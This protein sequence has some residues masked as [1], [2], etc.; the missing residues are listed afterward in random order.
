[1][2]DDV[3]VP[4]F[5]VPDPQRVLDTFD[6]KNLTGPSGFLSWLGLALEDSAGLLLAAGLMDHNA[7]QPSRVTDEE[8]GVRD[9]SQKLMWLIAST[10]RVYNAEWVPRRGIRFETVHQRA[11]VLV[12]DEYEI[13]ALA[14]QGAH[15]A[16]LHLAWALRCFARDETDAVVVELEDA[17]AG[18]LAA[19]AVADAYRATEGSAT[20]DGSV[21]SAPP[22]EGPDETARAKTAVE[23]AAINYLNTV[24]T[25]RTID[26]RPY[27][28]VITV[29][30]GHP[31][32]TT[33]LPQPRTVGVGA[34]LWMRAVREHD[35]LL[36]CA[37]VEFLWPSAPNDHRGRAVEITVEESDPAREV[38]ILAELSADPGGN[39]RIG[40]ITRHPAGAA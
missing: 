35:D 19:Y 24:S 12:E 10:L 18:A 15:S 5:D 7:D 23:H 32:K 26:T 40:R 30:R 20:Q 3:G 34:E 16:A 14:T 1:M 21:A 29:F 37:T 8:L 13:G 4:T 36:A 39:V 33:V 22:A 2:R 31:P 38:V 27:D 6:S 9:G 28:V 17:L 25:S 11:C